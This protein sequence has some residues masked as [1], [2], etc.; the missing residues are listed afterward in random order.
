MD[1]EVRN[2]FGNVDYRLANMARVA[3]GESDPHWYFDNT[4]VSVFVR[5]IRSRTIIVPSTL[6]S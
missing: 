6:V 3:Q 4:A 2:L 5:G 1:Y